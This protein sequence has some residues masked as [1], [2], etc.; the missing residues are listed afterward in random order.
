LISVSSSSLKNEYE[1]SGTAISP[2]PNGLKNNCCLLYEIATGQI[3]TEISSLFSI[4]SFSFSSDGNSKYK[5][6]GKLLV[7]GSQ[8]GIVCVWAL[9][10]AIHEN[11][12]HVMTA[13]KT[14]PNFWSSY[15]I[16]IDSP[17]RSESGRP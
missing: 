10:E 7:V 15:P 11:I 9:G 2:A 12:K 17:R 5:N 8:E 16:F 14:K 13:M 1:F 6:I 4:S 3:A